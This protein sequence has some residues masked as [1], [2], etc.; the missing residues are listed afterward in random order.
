MNG[1]MIL[2]SFP[3]SHDFKA[4]ALVTMI[5]VPLHNSDILWGRQ[6]QLKAVEGSYTLK[7][8]AFEQG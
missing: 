7:M 8:P 4:L 1:R 6:V 2:F 3:C 5:F